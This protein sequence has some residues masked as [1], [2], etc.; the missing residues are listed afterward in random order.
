MAAYRMTTNRSQS[1]QP[2]S[3]E[4]GRYVSESSM[5]L[6]AWRFSMAYLHACVIGRGQ[7]PALEGSDLLCITAK[8]CQAWL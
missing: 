3:Y 5:T 8:E 4:T 6:V 7:S 1:L 2:H